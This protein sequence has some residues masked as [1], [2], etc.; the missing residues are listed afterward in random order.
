M[1][2]AIL[3]FGGLTLIAG[4]IILFQPETI[5]GILR[6]NLD[7]VSL[8]ILAVAVRVLLGAALILYASESKYPLTLE[9]LGWVSLVAAVVL[10]LI[11]R[12]NFRR[13]MK[14]AL[15]LSSSYGRIGGG[16]AVLFGGFLIYAVL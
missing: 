1:G 14:W 16:V 2:Y 4:V 6:R 3:V 9:I 10:G 8:H 12:S 5:F 7:A 13:L 15:G 11:S